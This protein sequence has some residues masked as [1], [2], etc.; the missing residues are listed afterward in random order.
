MDL[1]ATD[2]TTEVDAQAV[3]DLADLELPSTPAG[4]P[5]S[6][7]LLGIGS[8]AMV[9][10]GVLLMLTGRIVMVPPTVGLGVIG[11]LVARSKL[12]STRTTVTS[13]RTSRTLRSGSIPK[14][15]LRTVGLHLD[16]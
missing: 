14:P 3:S 16:I 5:R 4:T 2:E 8:V 15:S 12:A 9:L 13:G 7:T 6:V 1:L 11:A 10:F